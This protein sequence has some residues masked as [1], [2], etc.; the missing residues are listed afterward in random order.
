MENL[1]EIV[2]RCKQNDPKAQEILFNSFSKSL[3]GICCRYLKNRDDAEDVLQDSFIKI[4]LNINQYRG[5]GNFEGWMKRITVNTA[6]TYLKEKQKIKFETA[7]KLYIV[8][9]PEE[10]IDQDIK[11]EY[12]LECLNELP[13]GY[14]T[15]FNLYLVEGFSHKEIADQLGIKEATSRSQYSKARQYLI[16]L[17]NKKELAKKTQWKAVSIMMSLLSA[18]WT[19]LAL[20]LAN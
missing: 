14:R 19:V 9:E 1:T 3:Y 13:M 17:I 18:S 2:N 8:D 10:E 5:E 11:A 20:S 15:I 7:D 16:E 4:L 12:I 6:L